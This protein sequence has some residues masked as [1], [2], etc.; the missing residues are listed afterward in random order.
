MAYYKTLIIVVCFTVACFLNIVDAQEKGATI[1][2]SKK[3]D[4]S[5][6]SFIFV[7]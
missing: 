7:L 4:I 3:F 5:I 2:K 1:G 6:F